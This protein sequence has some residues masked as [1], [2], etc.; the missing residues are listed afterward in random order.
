MSWRDL[1]EWMDEVEKLGE[2]RVV[3][4]ATWQEDI[5]RI[6]EMLDHTPD[7]P[8]VVFDK[9]PG[10]PAGRR[11]IVNCN[12]TRRR[13]AVTLDLPPEQATHEALLARWREILDN[14]KLVPPE[15]V[16]DAPVMEN[17][18]EG[19]DVDA[20]AFPAPVWHPKDGG[21]YIGTASLN[22]MRDPDE[23]WVNLGTYRNQ[24]LS[25]NQLGIW[26]SPGKHGR[27]I[28][29]KYFDR[30]ERCPIVVVVGSDPLLFWAAC[31]EGAPYGV[32][33]LDW[34]GGVRGRP[35]QVIEGPLTGLP[36]PAY[37]EI[38]LEGFMTPGEEHDEGP[39][40][41]WLGYYS[42]GR[43]VPFI[44]VA[45]IYHRNDPIILGCPQGKPP[46][47]DNQFLA[48]LKSELIRR[49][50]EAAGIS[51]VTGVWCPPEGGNRLL[52]IIRLQQR[53][54][55]H[56]R[57]VA[58]VAAQCGAA[59][60]NGRYVVVVDDDIDIFD[61]REVLWA[62][63]TRSDPEGDIEFIARA[64]SSPIDP[65]VPPGAPPFNSR[66]LIDA[67]IPWERRDTFPEAIVDVHY[68]RETREKWG[69]ILR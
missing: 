52:V 68:A 21:Q 69:H 17:V 40:G 7:A 67:T 30:G 37:A 25:A 48:Y 8:C 14:L 44:Q 29:Q 24:I 66:A 49:Q 36:I 27:I 20:Q 63:L 12:G 56:A 15:F 38:A 13:Q 59:A 23:G 61:L 62:V 41:E 2:L 50:I 51:G 60:Y 39:Y 65:M 31:V 9:I 42:E 64:W 57:Q 6:T 43:K 5:G 47:E 35:V 54:A 19:E 58:H 34:V 33:E 10:Y 11:V 16:A 32:S 46:H 4:G 53:Y 28:R 3:E 18:I 55:G 1:R 45:A 26:I 22:I